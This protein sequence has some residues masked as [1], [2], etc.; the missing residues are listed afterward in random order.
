MNYQA[1]IEAFMQS[2]LEFDDWLFTFPLAEQ[3]VVMRA[4]KEYA[5]SIALEDENFEMAQSLAKLDERIDAYEDAIAEELDAQENYE[6]A[7]ANQEEVFAAIDETIQEV[8]DYIME[9][10]VTEA[11]NAKDM[12]GLAHKIIATEKENDLY[13]P[14]NWKPILHLLY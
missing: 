3:P 6:V 7:L 10:I 12:L 8:R 2:D 5:L 1:E 11:D 14:K 4:Y 13:D 9:C